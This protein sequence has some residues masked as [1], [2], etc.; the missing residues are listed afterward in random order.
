MDD[1]LSLTE[2]TLTFVAPEHWTRDQVEGWMATVV[3]AAN[4]AT[5][6]IRQARN[7]LRLVD[8][9]LTPDTEV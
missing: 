2:R 1:R 9:D 5:S 3:D 7:H 8:D 6:G 4:E